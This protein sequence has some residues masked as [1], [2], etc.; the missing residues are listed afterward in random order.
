MEI[1]YKS[2]DIEL[3]KNKLEDSKDKFEYK[4]NGETLQKFLEMSNNVNENFFDEN[5]FKK[6]IKTFVSGFINK[7]FDNIIV[8]AGAGASVVTEKGMINR[9]YGKTI[10]MIAELVE[11][12]LSENGNKYYS[13]EQL[14]TMSKFENELYEN[15]KELLN[16]FNLEDFLSNL[17]Q[18]EKYVENG[19][20]DKF[21]RSKNKILDTIKEGVRYEYNSEIMKHGKLIKILS[22]K[23]KSPNKLSVVTTNYDILFEEAANELNFTVIDGFSFTYKPKFDID[24]F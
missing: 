21:L 23:I 3:S 13:L 19:K 16:D 24:I 1:Y 15:N 10:R 2:R 5:D 9:S 18:Y 22:D 14:A 4:R 6:L 17:M 7:S 11:Q 8:L 12:K 20:K